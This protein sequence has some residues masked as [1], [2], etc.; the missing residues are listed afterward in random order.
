LNIPNN[1]IRDAFAIKYFQKNNGKISVL[2]Q[3]SP[4]G[5]NFGIEMG[6]TNNLG[7]KP[8]REK[9]EKIIT[10]ENLQ[11]YLGK[12]ELRLFEN[13]YK[14]VSNGLFPAIPYI[15]TL[16]KTHR[17]NQKVIKKY[18]EVVCALVEKVD[19][20]ENMIEEHNK[21]MKKAYDVLDLGKNSN[22]KSPVKDIQL[23]IKF[24]R[25]TLLKKLLKF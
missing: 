21:F 22:K 8:I 3:N 23:K 18:D 1:T 4:R 25:A 10:S 2:F 12:M 24:P 15:N 14:T 5:I 11:N 20:Y 9:N 17:E 7:Y 13:E 16:E 6:S 19:Y